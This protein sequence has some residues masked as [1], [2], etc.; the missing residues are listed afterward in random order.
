MKKASFTVE[1]AFIMPI[2][3][4]IVFMLMY[5]TFLLHDR[6]VLQGNFEYVLCKTAEKKMAKGDCKKRLSEGLWLTKLHTVNIERSMGKVSGEAGGSTYLK[7]PVMSPFIK[8]KQKVQ[9]SGEYYYLQP[10][11]FIK[12]KEEKDGGKVHKEGE[13]GEENGTD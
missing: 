11:Q 10:E 1:A 9:C 6:S 8:L 12:L 3:L 7:I 13:A 2:I 4:G 5:V